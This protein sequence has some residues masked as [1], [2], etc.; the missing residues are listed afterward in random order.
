MNGVR[1]V[2]APLVI[3]SVRDGTR[4]RFVERG[5]EDEGAWLGI[6]DFMRDTLAGKRVEGWYAPYF[7]SRF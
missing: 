7:V 6:T 4:V 2:R 3:T 1:E 5:R